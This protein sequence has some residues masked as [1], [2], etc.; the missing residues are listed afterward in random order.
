VRTERNLQNSLLNPDES[1]SPVDLECRIPAICAFFGRLTRE[2]QKLKTRWRRG[3]DSNPRATFAAAV[4]KFDT[5]LSCIVHFIC[6]H[7]VFAVRAFANVHPD[8]VPSITLVQRG[9]RLL[10]SAVRAHGS[11]GGL[12]PRLVNRP[13]LFC[14]EREC[15]HP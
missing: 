10:F 15:H 8:S 9:G 2:S 6:W 11:I 14:R 4:F 5:G 13:V 1:S 12:S 7:R 3:W